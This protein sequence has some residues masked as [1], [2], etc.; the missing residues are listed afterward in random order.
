VPEH[1]GFGS[2]ER[3]AWLDDFADLALYYDE[4]LDTLELDGVHLVGHSVGGWIAAEFAVFYPK[5]VKSLTL[6][7]PMGLRVPGHPLYDVFRMTEENAASVLLNG[8]AAAYGELELTATS[9][10]ARVAAYD[11][12]TTLARL[13]WN[14]RYDLKLDQ[15][16]DRVRCPALIV[17]PDEDRVVP[18]A[19]ME[20]WVELL[21]DA[22]L[23]TVSGGTSPTGHLLVA[24]EPERTAATIASFL[25]GVG[26]GS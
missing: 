4:L 20:R 13:M 15:R 3:P 8:D 18:A 19:H 16:L 22:R 10:E 14:P 23:E 7:A 24:Q 5:R 6:I 21:P 17:V 1:P 9:V 25:A 2:I 11:E 26:A 12:F